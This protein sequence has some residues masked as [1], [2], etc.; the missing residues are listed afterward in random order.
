M[1]EVI[2]CLKEFAGL[3]EAEQPPYL[4]RIGAFLTLNTL[5][6]PLITYPGTTITTHAMS[7]L[8]MLG[9]KDTS[10]LA[11]SN[12]IAEL[13]LCNT[14]METDYIDIDAVA[15]GDAAI[16]AK[17]GAKGTSAN[18]SRIGIASTPSDLKYVVLDTTGAGEM[19][20]TRNIDKL[21]TGGLIV[22][23]TDTKITVVKSGNTQLKI[24]TGDG[25]TIFVDVD[26]ASKTF[27]QNQIKATE[28]NSVVTLFNTNGISNVASPTPVVIPR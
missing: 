2:N 7:L 23:F 1:K 21:A 25:T 3:K 8:G 6:F 19:L 4:I 24:T 5:T 10:D 16:V 28:I 15:L 22:T 26:T 27:I 14:M 13:A 11:M 12:Y 17:S 20:I 18:T 9:L